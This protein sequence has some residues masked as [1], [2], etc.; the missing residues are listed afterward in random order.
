MFAEPFRN[1]NVKRLV[2]AILPVAALALTAAA[3]DAPALQV[4]GDFSAGQWQVSPADAD[5]RM[6]RPKG[7]NQCLADVMPIVH[8]G[9]ESAAAGACTHT[10]VQDA[11]DRGI[12]TYVC[13]GQG[14]G[15]TDIRKLPDGGYIVDAQGIAGSDPYEM[16]GVFKRTGDCRR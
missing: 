15:R 14:Y 7:D 9:H 3:T 8:A 13:K 2:L 12:V 1:R 5:S 6:R 11:A 16:K 10:V 4:L